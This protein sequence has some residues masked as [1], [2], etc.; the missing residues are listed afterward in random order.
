MN[1]FNPI[2]ALVSGVV[3]I[4]EKKQARKANKEQAEAKLK[5]SKVTNAHEV[6]LTDA[7]GEALLAEGLVDSWK[8]E[9]V[10]I[11]VTAPIVMIIVGVTYFAFTGDDRLLDS[12]IGSIKA[13]KESGVDMGFLMNAV[14]LS[15]I[16]L[17]IWRKA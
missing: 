10:T 16:G 17:K 15:A 8:D 2:T 1:W 3:G 13:L 12:G 5:Q 14:V 11:V 6:T 7:E 4:F 9:Y